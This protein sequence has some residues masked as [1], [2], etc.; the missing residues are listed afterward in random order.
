MRRALTAFGGLVLAVLIAYGAF[1]LIDLG[2]R[3]SFEVRANYGAVR[4]LEV[5]GTGDVHLIGAPAGSG[6]GVI[7]HVTEGLVT[8]HREAV[9]ATG[10]VLH[11]ASSC[12]TFF[13]HSCGVSYTIAVPPGVTITADSGDGNVDTH[14]L[15][16]TGQLKLSSGNGDVDAVGINAGNVKLESGNGDVNA[17]LTRAPARLEASSGNGDV[18]LTVPNTTYAVHASSGNGS[19]SD[20]TL[21]IDPSSPRTIV[22]SSGNGDVTIRAAGASAR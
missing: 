8:P 6:V 14:G 18:N 22:A 4:S 9:R 19:V 11:L 17:R 21:R 15:I 10:G 13:D 16:V 20:Q 7:E 5:D 3:H 12:S 2:S 1:T